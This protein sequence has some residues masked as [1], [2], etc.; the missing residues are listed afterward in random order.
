ML[1]PCGVQAP[2]VNAGACSMSRKLA[3]FREGGD[4][5]QI[6]TK[7][8]PTNVKYKANGLAVSPVGSC[9]SLV[10]IK[11]EITVKS[12]LSS[13]GPCFEHLFLRGRAILACYEPLGDRD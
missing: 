12:E 9:E 5:T 6:V 4:A 13:T 10:L 8:C 1:N 11:G 2:T 3:G 7:A